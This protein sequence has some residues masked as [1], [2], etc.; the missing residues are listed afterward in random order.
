MS[1]SIWLSDAVDSRLENLAVITGRS[2]TFFVAQAV[3]EHLEDLENMYL[4]EHELAG[5]YAELPGT[6]PHAGAMTNYEMNS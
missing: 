3:L 2:K 4:A 6:N 1:V 5:I